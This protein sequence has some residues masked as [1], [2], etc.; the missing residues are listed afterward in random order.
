M[1]YNY[2]GLDIIKYPTLDVM[3]CMFI[4]N[5]VLIVDSDELNQALANFTYSGRG[6]GLSVIIQGTHSNVHIHVEDSDFL[7]NS[8]Q[9]YGGGLYA[10]ISGE[11]TY[12]VFKVDSCRFIGNFGGVDGFG[13]GLIYSLLLKNQNSER[14]V[15]IELDDCYFERNLASNGAGLAVIEVSL[16]KSLTH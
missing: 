1:A 11:G 15:L 7:D 12:H 14:P 16:E 13:G 6:G 4:N 9:A 3:E 10:L 2:E 8:A 5:S